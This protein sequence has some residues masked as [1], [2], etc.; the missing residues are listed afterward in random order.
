MKSTPLDSAI[1]ASLNLS[2]GTATV[3]PYGGSGFSQTA[4]ITTTSG[5]TYFLKTGKGA[6]QRLML[7]GM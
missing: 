4:K 3:H 5:L 6:S 1:A 2:P 7:E